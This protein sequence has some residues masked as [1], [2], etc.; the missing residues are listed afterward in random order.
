MGFIPLF[1][2]VSAR[3]C[4]VIGGG[5][6]AA[7]RARALIE[8]GASV[9]VMAQ[10]PG[11]GIAALAE[12]GA[13]RLLACAYT[14]GA[15]RDY[16]LAYVTVPDAE[17]ARD[18]AVEA[19][20]LGIPLNVEDRPDLCSFIAPS[21]VKRGDLQIA[22]STGGASPALAKLLREELDLRFGPEYGFL[23]QILAAAR[24]RLRRS[25]PD[26]AMRA[27]I[28]DTL[29]RSELREHLRAR[30]YD[31]AEQIVALHL[32]CGLSELGFDQTRSAAAAMGDVYD[33]E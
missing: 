32:G 16:V 9:T 8:A 13:L 10:E 23:A 26:A 33:P 27:Q 5:E 7:R 30:N 25:E 28:L 24:R 22:V 4:L 18:A 1:F 11:A 31:A 6:S 17:V 12:C 19:R 2:D 14:R 21:V 20:E 3:P 29:V 15:L